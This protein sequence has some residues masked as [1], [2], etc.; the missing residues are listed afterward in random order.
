[1]AAQSAE[2][3]PEQRDFRTAMANL[4]AGVN[5]VTTDGPFGKA[6]ITVSAACSVTDSPP[7]VLVC[8]NRSSYNHDVLTANRRVCVN[9]LGA[10]QQD[11]ALHFAGATGLSNEERFGGGVC[12]PAYDDVPVLREAAVSLIGRIS[13]V[14]VHGSHSVVFV[15]VERV[16]VR[17]DSGGLVY[18]KRRFHRVDIYG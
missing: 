5:I 2:I 8:V 18:F 4:P 3:T 9:V 7:T 10:D 6:G 16:I 13:D 12:D 11:L 14:Y 17:Q 15:A 1:M